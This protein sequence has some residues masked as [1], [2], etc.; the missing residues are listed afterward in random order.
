VLGVRKSAVHLAQGE[1]ARDK[2]FQVDDT[3]LSA[4]RAALE[5][6]LA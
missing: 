1:T 5:K 2:L 6:A 4:V 3:S